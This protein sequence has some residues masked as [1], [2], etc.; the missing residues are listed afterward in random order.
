MCHSG[1][2]TVTDSTTAACKRQST[3][4][5]LRAEVSVWQGPRGDA[6][7]APGL[8][9]LSLSLAQLPAQRPRLGAAGRWAE[10][11]ELLERGPGG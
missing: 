10:H 9:P 4:R 6:G 5:R 11:G 1:A 3:P 7:G 2:W 8:L